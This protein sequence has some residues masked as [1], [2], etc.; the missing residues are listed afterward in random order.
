ME[1]LNVWFG[2]A[3]LAYV[4]LIYGMWRFWYPRDPLRRRHEQAGPIR[5]AA[6]TGQLG[7][8]SS[9]S[10]LYLLDDEVLLQKGDA[11][12]Y[13]SRDETPVVGGVVR[14]AGGGWL[15]GTQ[16]NRPG[17]TYQETG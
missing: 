10:G 3:V 2:L 15:F 11:S 4:G 14:I 13:T 9:P 16:R 7:R 12:L 5:Q 6:S 8:L 17:T 1:W